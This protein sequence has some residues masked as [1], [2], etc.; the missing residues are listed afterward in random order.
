MEKLRT[1]Q[2]SQTAARSQHWGVIYEKVGRQVHD[3]VLAVVVRIVTTTR[4]NSCNAEM[5]VRLSHFESILP[6]RR[7][8]TFACHVLV[9]YQ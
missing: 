6:P 2:M 3:V 5:K 1:G 4:F 8:I 7:C 9:Q